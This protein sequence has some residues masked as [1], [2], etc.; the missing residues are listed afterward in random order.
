MANTTSP[1]SG[2]KTHYQVVEWVRQPVTALVERL[3]WLV[4]AVGARLYAVDDRMA[5]H[6]G[7]AITRRCAELA[8]SYRDPRFDTLHICSPCGGRGAAEERQCPP[9][10]GTGRVTLGAPQ[11]DAGAPEFGSGAPQFEGQRP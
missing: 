10:D 3:S 1:T 8:R 5:L 6:D 11:F 7:W 9:C 4:A 2:N